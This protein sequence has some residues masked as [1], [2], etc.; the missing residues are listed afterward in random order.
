MVGEDECPGLYF[1]SVNDIFTKLE[2][3]SAIITE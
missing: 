2:E 3:R 1:S